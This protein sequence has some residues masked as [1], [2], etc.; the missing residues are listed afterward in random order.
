MFGTLHKQN[1]LKPCRKT[2]S[3]QQPTSYLSPEKV[4]TEFN[5]TPS[6]CQYQQQEQ[7][8]INEVSEND[9]PSIQNGSS[10]F[11]QDEDQLI[12]L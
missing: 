10:T 2:S 6:L 1:S 9:F 8:A 4:A 11:S 12:L 5:V 7:T 3:M